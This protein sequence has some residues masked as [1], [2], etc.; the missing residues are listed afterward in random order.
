MNLLRR[1][2]SWVLILGVIIQF[3][4]YRGTTAAVVNPPQPAP[5]NLR[6]K[7][8]GIDKTDASAARCYVDLEWDELRDPEGITEDF[9]QYI[10]FYVQEVTKP[11]KP[12]KAVT[13]KERDVSGTSRSLRMRGLTSGT[14]Y[15]INSRAYY[16]YTYDD[17]GT[18]YT[19]GESQYSNTVKV[20]TDIEIAAYSYGTNKIKIEWDDVWNVG[21]RMDYKLYVSE[22]SSFANTS[23]IYIGQEQIG[24]NGPVTVNEASGKLE[25][26]HTVRDPG[27][28]YY[29]KIVPDTSESGLVKNPESKTVAVSSYILAKTTKMSETDAGTIWRLEWRPVITGLTD[30]DIKITYQIDKFVNNVPI[31]ML[32]EE[33]TSTFILV[34]RGEENNYY[35]IRA[36]VTKNGVPV[37]PGIKI[38]SDRIMVR[39]QEVPSTPPAPELVDAF[40]NSYDEPVISYDDLLDSSGNLIKKGE[41]T[42]NTA[43]ILWR[44]PKKAD[45]SIDTDITY[46]IWLIS[47]PNAIDFP[48]NETM[49]ASSL[50]MSSNNFVMD[51]SRVIGYK[52][53]ISNLTPNSTYYFKVV[54]RKTYVEYVEEELENVEYISMP[55]LKVIITP[56]E[57]PIDQPLVP[58]RPPL[59][60][61]KSL[62][63][64]EL[65]TDTTAVIQL[66]NK[67]YE[68]YDPIKGKWEYIRSEKLSLDDLVPPPYDPYNPET[69]PDGEPLSDGTRYRVV[70]YDEGVTI[71][72]GC[73]RYEEGMTYDDLYN[74][75]ANKVRGFPVYSNDPDEDPKLNAPEQKDPYVYKKHN[76]DIT[77]TGLEPN[78]TYVV[79][80]RANRPGVNMTSDPSD[81]ILITTD[82]VIATPV[83]KPTVPLFNYSQ[84]GDTFADLGWEIKPNYNYY[85]KYGTADDVS[86]AAGTISLKPEDLRYTSYCRVTGLKPNTVY[87]FWIQAEATDGSQSVKSEWSDSYPIRTL[88]DIPPNTPRGFGIK[89]AEDAVAKNSLTF[90]WLK[91][92]GL[93][94]ILQIASDID[95]SDIKEYKIGNGSEFTVVGLLSNHR[96]YARL[97][98]Y[99]PQKKLA[100][101]PTQSITVRTLRSSDDY[102]SDQNIENVVS[103]DYVEKDTT[104]INGAWNVKIIGVNADRFIEH[105][106]NDRILDYKIDLRKPPS[107]TA[108]ICLIIDSRVFEAL[109][110]MKE[111]LILETSESRLVI[112]PGMLDASLA[113]QKFSRSDGFNYQI[114]ISAEDAAKNTNQY[115]MIFKTKVV[116]VA[117]NTSEGSTAV[118]VKKFG[119]PLKV[120]FPYSGDNWYRE[121]KTSGFI[122]KPDIDKWEIAATQNIFNADTGKGYAAFETLYPGKMAIADKGNRYFDDINGHI[123]ESSINNVAAVHEIKSIGGRLF[124]P[125]KACTM[126][127]AVKFMLDIM[128]YQYGSDFMA[129]AAKTGM[130]FRE[131]ASNLGAGCTR[132]KAIVMVARLYELK[133]GETASSINEGISIFDDM[134]KVDR[135]LLPKVE[136]AVENGIAIGK[137]PH[138]LCPKDIITRGEIMGLLER[139]LVLIGEI[140]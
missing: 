106:M 136:F 31:P 25:Y 129:V 53:V 40:Y 9:H 43:T 76:V 50:T 122:Y 77:L 24:P 61:K 28:V 92:D 72:V 33:G 3:A 29:V 46:D 121:G 48:P 58:A 114:H 5:E 70:E 69:P 126:S 1:L 111:N 110:G 66:K 130:I 78:T 4:W 6:V 52:Y 135:R 80:V 113:G 2:V 42:P 107:K 117:I 16:T 105:I 45:G 104:V 115:K 51:G 7:E 118:P 71:D 68:K 36:M 49:L 123:F 41:L 132:E 96:Y 90:E 60:V 103:G 125:D 47:D 98:A 64:V 44:V 62:N 21:R 89:N 85:L 13:L 27:R 87:Y 12:A 112:R 73:I 30:G 133:T 81:P 134:D 91:E 10:N 108:K 63:G 120:M 95:Y 127:E 54:A 83:E 82:P 15:Y 17:T 97:F 8:I 79:W 65:I 32:I 128:D 20:L 34:P 124:Q 23:P 14:I 74:L 99:D 139:L 131:D 109:T 102:D 116:N 57:G 75:P 86:K 18:T 138:H 11:Y 84:A 94:Y 55:S 35:I 37:Y 137:D 119:K 59:K 101:Q 19:S 88:Q 100:S 56:T 93:E 140:D 67:W 38:E 26:I 22:N 39:E